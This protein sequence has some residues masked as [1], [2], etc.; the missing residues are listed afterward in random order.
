MKDKETIQVIHHSYT[1][2]SITQSNHRT[3]RTSHSTVAARGAPRHERSSQLRHISFSN[4][5]SKVTEESHLDSSIEEKAF[6]ARIKKACSNLSFY[7][8]D[9]KDME[10][11]EFIEARVKNFN[12][13]LVDDDLST[14]GASTVPAATPNG[15]RKNKRD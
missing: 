2:D 7:D 10:M 12:P 9:G 1:H 8:P 5:R 14:L 3:M 11:E 15:K 4:F 6:R 13:D